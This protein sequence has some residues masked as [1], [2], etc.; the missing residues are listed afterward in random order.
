M[1]LKR[2]KKYKRIII[3]S[4][5]IA[6]L[7]IGGYAAFAATQEIWPFAAD[8]AENVDHNP[9]SDDQRKAGEE[10]SQQAK[11]AESAA[12]EDPKQND[13]SEGGDTSDVAL[14]ITSAEQQ[15]DQLQIRTLIHS[16]QAGT[17]TL[18]LS[19]GGQTITRSA[20][21]QSMA[22]SS[23]CMGFDIPLS[24]LTTGEWTITI[25]YQGADL[26][27]TATQAVQVN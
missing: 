8:K 22:S 19:S 26:S 16:I 15:N 21:T 17:C 14:S 12:E 18:T 7:G 20:E 13:G 3:I 2:T 1:R 4:I 10:T 23:T 5:L 24:E 6:V 25:N 11:E 27:G 9:P